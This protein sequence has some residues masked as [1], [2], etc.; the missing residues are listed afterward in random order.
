MVEV[1]RCPHCQQRWPEQPGKVFSRICRK[2]HEPI[3][4]HHK[5]KVETDGEASWFAHRH[6]DNPTEYKPKE[7]A[8]QEMK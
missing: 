8:P 1:R 7:P 2:C 4:T 5:W 3:R 6:C